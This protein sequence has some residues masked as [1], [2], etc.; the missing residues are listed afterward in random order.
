LISINIKFKYYKT[1]KNTT[2]SKTQNPNF[3]ENPNFKYQKLGFGLL[4]F[5]GFWDFEIWIYDEYI[6]ELKL[7]GKLI[8]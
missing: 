4:D 5:L 8:I 6:K 3:K 1:Q 2:K 7:H